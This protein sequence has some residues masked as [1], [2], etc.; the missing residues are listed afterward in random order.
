MYRRLPG[1]VGVFLVI[2]D[3]I[4]AETIA[5]TSFECRPPADGY[6]EA[7]G[8]DGGFILTLTVVRGCHTVQT[9]R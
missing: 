8:V 5:V 3:M 1:A 7:C 2:R 6:S 9:I 4:M